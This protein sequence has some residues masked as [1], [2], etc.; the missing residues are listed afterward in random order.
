MAEIRRISNMGKK[1]TRLQ[2]WKTNITHT[3]NPGYSGGRDQEDQQFG[4][5]LSKKFWSPCLKNA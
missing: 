1:F 3:Y 4:T 5:S 2:Y